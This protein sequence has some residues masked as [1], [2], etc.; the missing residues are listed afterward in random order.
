MHG[1]SSKQGAGVAIHMVSPHKE[2]IEPL[3][4]LHFFASKNEAEYDALIVGMQLAYVVGAKQ[5]NAYDDSQHVANQ[6]SG[7]FWLATSSKQGMNAYKH[8]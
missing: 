7:E 8:M 1:Y 6:F 5:V 2:V 3:F 4:R